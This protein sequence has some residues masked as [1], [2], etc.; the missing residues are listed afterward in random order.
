MAC[1]DLPSASPPVGRTTFA[2]VPEKRLMLVAAIT[3]DP[4]CEW[5]PFCV[6]VEADESTGLDRR[7]YV[8]ASHVHS[9]SKE[10]LLRRPGRLG[11][12]RMEAVDLALRSMLDL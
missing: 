6:P 9:F 12:D 1:R 3:P 11:S 7:S 2:S 8:S 10:R 4:R 5:L